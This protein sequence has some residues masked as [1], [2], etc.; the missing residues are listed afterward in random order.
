MKLLRELR[1]LR[2][3]SR[4][5]VFGECDAAGDGA[6]IGLLVEDVFCFGVTV[7]YLNAAALFDQIVDHAFKSES[8]TIIRTIDPRNTIGM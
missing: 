5:S 7:L 2:K 4:L 3:L 8:A 1:G 6:D